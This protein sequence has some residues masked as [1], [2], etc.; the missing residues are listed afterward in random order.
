[1]SIHSIRLRKLLQIMYADTRLRTSKIREEIRNEIRAEEGASGGGGDFHTPFWAD[2]R[3]HVLGVQDLRDAVKDRI[4]GNKCRMRLYPALRD[5]FLSWWE[6]KRR[7]RNEPLNLLPT[8]AHASLVIPELMTEVKIENVMSLESGPDFQR[9]IYP[10]F[11]EKPSLS[12]EAG[13][14]GLWAMQEALQGYYEVADMRV[15]DVL[16]GRTF[17]TNDLPFQGNE[18]SIFVSRYASIIADWERLRKEY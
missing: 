10:Y 3:S 14:L 6:D 7:W 18:R 2:A 1:M 8:P 13:R 5:G 15:L 12:E 4:A 11:A 17:A 9:L 16:R